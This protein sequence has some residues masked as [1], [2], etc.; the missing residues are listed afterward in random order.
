MSTRTL[1]RVLLILVVAATAGGCGFRSYVR[2]AHDPA[3][4]ADRPCYS[5]DI[6][7]SGPYG[8]FVWVTDV[9]HS[10]GH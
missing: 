8:G 7:A 9:R 1:H 10:A 3:L 5:G 4:A 6:C 2:D